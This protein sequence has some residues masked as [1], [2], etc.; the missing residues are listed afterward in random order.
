MSYFEALQH[1]LQLKLVTL[2]EMPP[3]TN[4]VP[5]NFNAN[6]HCDYH[7]GGVGH[8]VENCWALKYKVHELLD[9]KAVQFT[10]VNAPNVI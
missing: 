6:A 8:D 4:K 9:S 1:L 3:L 2:K 10:S 5:A 7:S